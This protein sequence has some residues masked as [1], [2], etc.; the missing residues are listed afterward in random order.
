MLAEEVVAPVVVEVV[1][2]VEELVVTGADSEV[3]AEPGAQA[4]RARTNK[5]ARRRTDPEYG[6]LAWLQMF[7]ALRSPGLSS[8]TVLSIAPDGTWAP[9]PDGAEPE[10]GS[11]WWALPG[12]VDAHSHLAGD[13]LHFEPGEPNEIRRRAYSCLERGTFLVI[14]KG[15]NDDSV[16]VTLT[17]LDP[18]RRPDFEGAGRMIGVK[19]GYYP[20]FAVETDS[21]GLASVVAESTR[22]GKGWVK[23]VGDWPRK[24]LGPRANFDEEDLATAVSVAH[25][26]GSRVAIHTMAPEVPSMAVRA[27]VDSIEH[28]LFL[29]REDLENLAGRGGAWVPTVLRMELIA[30][31][32][33][34]DSSGGRL[35]LEG[36][37]NVSSLLAD[38]PGGVA[39]LAGTDMAT[40]PGDVAREAVAL[41]RRGLPTER[42]VA[43]ATNT[44]RSY[45][46]MPPGHEVGAPA[47]AI[48]VSSDPV[49]DVGVLQSPVAVM[50][51]GRLLG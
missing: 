25:R 36:L 48:F 10:I 6:A 39:V 32:L 9:A 41:A 21:E 37:E 23:L 30:D 44:A 31:M 34:H 43:A 45:V 14:D 7:V 8:A 20:D 16:I 33:G 1:D 3:G 26:A 51:H 13:D 12:L 5:E 46:G 18:M 42:A 15:W 19:G 24:G 47:D 27:G 50:R 38:T 28:G 11:G 22:E 17:D 29:S 40:A 49:E 4:A 2:D 35:I